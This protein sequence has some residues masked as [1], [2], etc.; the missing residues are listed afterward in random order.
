MNRP[1]DG[2]GGGAGACAPHPTMP[3]TPMAAADLDR[4]RIRS[5]AAPGT[6]VWAPLAAGLAGL[7]L[8]AGGCWLALRLAA[9][10]PLAVVT[11]AVRPPGTVSGAALVA[12]G[13]I[14]AAR[15]EQPVA[16]S[17]QIAERIVEIP[18][19]E[20][21]EVAPGGIVARLFSED[22]AQ[23]AAEAAAR[24]AHAEAGLRFAEAAAGRYAE[25][26]GQVSRDQ[27]ERT[28]ASADMARAALAEARAQQALA[29][30][31]LSFA[32]VTAPPAERP[33]R[34]LRLHHRVGDA[35]E[36]DGGRMIAELY[37]PERLQARVD[38]PQRQ[39]RAVRIGG[40]VELRTDAAPERR[41]RGRVLRLEPLADQAKN[42][43][44]VRIA[45]EDPDALLFPEMTCTVGF[46]ADPAAA[47]G[48]CPLVPRAA[49]RRDEEGAWVLADRDGLAVPVRFAPGPEAGAWV[50]AMDGLT[51]GERVLLDA[52]PAGARITEAP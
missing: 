35:L 49:V 14:E 15:P 42:T 5:G 48:D 22:L 11:A 41:Y 27:R 46:L 9:P 39:V 50:P 7:L 17:A 45:I 24:V 33:W 30:L 32:T 3:G 34:V 38:V 47:L 40:E 23:R 16:V 1:A 36:A 4:L 28:A 20:G 10:P 25:L 43:I 37:D 6:G 44:T 18:V 12:G 51:S 29:A 13:W 21:D 19:K 8:G 52:V 2:P 31:R 26:E